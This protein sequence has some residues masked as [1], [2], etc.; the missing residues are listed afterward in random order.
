MNTEPR[1]VRWRKSS[2]SGS[3]CVEVTVID[4]TDPNFKET[5]D[6]LAGAAHAVLAKTL[7]AAP[8]TG[9]SY[10]EA[11]LHLGA[12]LMYYGGDLVELALAGVLAGTWLWLPQ[13]RWR[14]TLAEVAASALYY[15]NWRLAVTAVDY[16]AGLHPTL[17][18]P[19]VWGLAAASAPLLTGLGAAAVLH[20]ARRARP[21]GP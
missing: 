4:K 8:P 2:H 10:P 13:D 9:T 18:G 12:Q 16:L 5:A 6:L 14:D 19:E 11:D 20:G 7:Y 15:E 1:R 3:N 17:P 21:A